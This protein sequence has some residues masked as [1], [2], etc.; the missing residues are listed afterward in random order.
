MHGASVAE[1]FLACVL[2]TKLTLTNPDPN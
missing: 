1:G 2:L